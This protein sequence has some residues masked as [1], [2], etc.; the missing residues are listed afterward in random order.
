MMA[1]FEATMAKHDEAL[2][3]AQQKKLLRDKNDWYKRQM[4]SSQ[5]D[6]NAPQNLPDYLQRFKFT[7]PINTEELMQAFKSGDYDLGADE[8][9]LYRL[10]Q[11]INRGDNERAASVIEKMGLVGIKNKNI[12]KE[13]F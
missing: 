13:L 7:G 12:E 5:V 1:L 4:T 11:L 8:A 6:K 2:T 10:R 9:D 3:I